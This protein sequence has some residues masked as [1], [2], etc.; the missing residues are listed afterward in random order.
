MSPLS[1]CG[2]GVG[3]EGRFPQRVPNR[4]EHRLGTL[5]DVVI[6]EAQDPEALLIQPRVANC[7]FRRIGVL[8]AVRLDDQACTE[9]H[10]V[11]DVRTDRLLTAELLSIES[12]GAEMTPKHV[13]GFGH[14]ST[15]LSGKRALIHAPSPQPLSR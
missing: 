5:E 4:F 3:G 13:L 9:M 10:E 1:P 15:Q 6:P 7:V 12:V 14:V 2:R 11:H 8:A